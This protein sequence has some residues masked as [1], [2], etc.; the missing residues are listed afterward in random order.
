VKADQCDANRIGHL[1]QCGVPQ[2]ILAIQTDRIG[3]YTRTINTS[4]DVH[5]LSNFLGNLGISLDAN[6]DQTTFARLETTDV[7]VQSINLLQ[8]DM[9][10]NEASPEDLHPSCRSWLDEQDVFIVGEGLQLRNGRLTFHRR[11]GTQVEASAVA[12][13]LDFNANATAQLTDSG[14]LTIADN[15][16]THIRRMRLVGRNLEF[17]PAQAA[18]RTAFYMSPLLSH[19][20]L[21]MALIQGQR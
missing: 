3:E 15:A 5:F 2:E 9:W 8:L 21:F 12:T 14:V 10:L 17:V 20:D 19:D 7:V 1:S 16:Y 13:M 4:Y 18:G 11:S 6:T